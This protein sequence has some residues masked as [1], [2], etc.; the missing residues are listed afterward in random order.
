MSGNLP[1][2]LIYEQTLPNPEMKELVN[3][4]FQHN[5]TTADS[6]VHQQRDNKKEFNVYFQN[7]LQWRFTK[8]FKSTLNTTLTVRNGLNDLKAY[9]L[10]EELLATYSPKWS[11]YFLSNKIAIP[12]RFM[13][14]YT[15]DNGIFISPDIRY[16]AQ[17]IHGKVNRNL[18]R[19]HRNDHFINPGLSAGYI[20]PKLG[21]IRVSYQPTYKQPELLQL[22]PDSIFQTP[23]SVRVGNMNLK[24]SFSQQFNFQYSHFFPRLKFNVSGM[25]FNRFT[26]N[27]VVNSQYV[28]I[29]EAKGVVYNTLSFTNLDGARQSNNQ[30]NLAKNIT[31]FNSSIRYVGSL[32]LIKSP[33]LQENQLYSFSSELQSHTLS[34]QLTP[35]KWVDLSPSYQF[36]RN[37]DNNSLMLEGPAIVNTFQTAGMDAQFYLPFELQIRTFVG[38]YTQ[39]FAL[40]ARKSHRWIINANVEK[41]LFKKKDAMLSLLLMDALREKRRNSLSRF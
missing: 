34:F 17:W 37:K 23:F 4:H 8:K 3:L 24:N 10:D 13:M 30:I 12:V 2:I 36:E 25:S 15:F 28:H 5:A 32:Q 38:S 26:T 7:Q 16:E 9:Q 33:F 14:E 39:D 27:E 18:N 31:K 19:I 21:S 11:N 29:D 20:N 41:R 6:S 22:N 40:T 1:Q 35:A